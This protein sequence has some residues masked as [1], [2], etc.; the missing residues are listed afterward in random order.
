MALNK[1]IQHQS[2]AYANYW[3]IKETNLNYV[4]KSGSI[5]IDGY[6]SQ[7]ARNENKTPLMSKE[8]LATNQ[9]FETWFLPVNVDPLNINQVKNSYLFLKTTQDFLGAEDI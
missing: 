8:V 4:S 5:V 1:I 7:E 9:D 3:K 6:V 2:G